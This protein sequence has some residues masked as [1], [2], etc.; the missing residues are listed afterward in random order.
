[1]SFSIKETTENGL[2]LIRLIEKKTGTEVDILPSYGA[3]LHAFRINVEGSPLN[4][5]DHYESL[6]QLK[7]QL[8]RSYKSSKLSPF[9]CRIHEGKYSY[10]GKQYEFENKFVDGSAIHGLLYNKSF[11]IIEQHADEGFAAVSLKYEYRKNDLQYPFDYSCEVIYTLFPDQVLEVIT[12]V[13]NESNDSIPIADGWHPYFSLGGKVDEW[14][15]HFNAISLV[16]FDSKL[17]PTGRQLKYEE[18]QVPMT[19]GKTELDNCFQVRYEKGMPACE[20]FNPF[21]KLKVSFFPDSSYPYLQ[22][23]TA[24]HRKSI[25][26]ENLSAA[27]DSFNNKMGL[28]ILYPGEAQ[29]FG[30]QYKLSLV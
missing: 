3:L 16:E 2:S 21:N 17:V 29:S 26:I 5:I 25:A 27:P 9:P 4:V 23:Y 24:P 22:I 7:S 10:N 15:M 18:F 8:D 11:S 19:I 30:L 20:I 28:S 12:R 13:I 6:D 14:L 1:M